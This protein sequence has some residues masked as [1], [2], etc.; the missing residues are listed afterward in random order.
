MSLCEFLLL[1]DFYYISYLKQSSRSNAKQI[2]E[3][4]KRRELEMFNLNGTMR[5]NQII[6]TCVYML[7]TNCFSLD[8]PF[9]DAKK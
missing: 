9:L 1:N 2:I 4:T 6:L 7:E 8:H 5:R 3:H